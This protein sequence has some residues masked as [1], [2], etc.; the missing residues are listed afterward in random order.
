MPTQTKNDN[1]MSWIRH[2]KLVKKTRKKFQYYQDYEL[3][4]ESR[5]TGVLNYRDKAIYCSMLT[6][7]KDR[8]GLYRYNLR[9]K[10]AYN[11]PANPNPYPERNASEDGYF[12]KEGHAEEIVSLLSLFFQ[13]R[14]YILSS[15]SVLPDGM[16][17]H[18]FEKDFFYKPVESAIHPTIFSTKGR[19]FS[20]GLTEFLDK[21]IKLPMKFHQ[22]FLW[23]SFH[24]SQAL[25][26]VGMDTE[27]VFIKL[28]SAIEILTHHIEIDPKVD[29]F[30]NKK[31]SEMTDLSGLTEEQRK[32]AEKIFEVRNAGLKF[33]SFIEKYCT[34][35]FKGGGSK[36]P[37]CKIRR[38]GLLKVL[39]T[40]YSA[41][42]AYLHSGESMY[43]SM[44]MRMKEARKWDTDPSMGM[45]IDN[46]DFP[47]SKKL[48]YAYFF[49]SLVRH[50]LL[51]FLRK[52]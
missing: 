1:R 34:G 17:R 26:Q 2:L 14:F 31:L 11:D 46:R 27:M 9:I 50:C 45:I 18:K 12:F 16:S 6:S 52:N 35:F 21:T 5:I 25:R 38:S 19:S 8:N 48:P 49:E 7:E 23:A 43:L 24:Y 28:V 41:R 33:K 29:V 36:A 39:N 22:N 42:S 51:S 44:P 15:S 10:S 40:I 3:V 30:G 37:H 47:A 4:S 20:V 13:S 32:R